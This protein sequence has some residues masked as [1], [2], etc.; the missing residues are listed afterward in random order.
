M[1]DNRNMKAVNKPFETLVEFR[2]IKMAVT[3]QN[4]IHE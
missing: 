2:Y 1:Q 3:N 4:Y